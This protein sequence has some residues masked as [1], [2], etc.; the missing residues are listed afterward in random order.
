MK[1][2]FQRL[3]G[4][5]GEERDESARADAIRERLLRERI[6][7]LGTPIDDACAD[8]T[9]AQ[10]LF[11]ES[12]DAE[13][14]VTIYVNS[15]GG[16]V[17]ASLAIYDTMLRLRPDVSTV[18]I[19]SAGGL[20]AL[21]VAAGARGKRFA[22]PD[23]SF[24]LVPL[25]IGGTADLSRE[26]AREVERMTML[27]ARCFSRATRWDVDATRRDLERGLELTAERAVEYGL[28]DQVLASR[29]VRSP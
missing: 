26:Q 2:V 5:L 13:R 27:I 20:A 1:S 16:S 19:G 8:L 10:L 25:R 11:L 3:L 6:I 18:C 17:P 28:V 14:D 15:P 9:V 7:F 23:A 24:K 29:P 22:V 21:L 4:N 12:E